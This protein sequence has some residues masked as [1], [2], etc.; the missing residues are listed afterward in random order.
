MGTICQPRFSSS[1]RTSRTNLSHSVD[2]SLAFDTNVSQRRLQMQ[3]VRIA[4]VHYRF[5]QN[6]QTHCIPRISF[7]G[8]QGLT[9]DRSMLN[10]CALLGLSSISQELSYSSDRQTTAL[11]QFSRRRIKDA[12]LFLATC[13][14]SPT[15]YVRPTRKRPKTSQRIQL[16]EPT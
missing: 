1:S 2:R 3:F 9:L 10:L 12:R 14:I 5:I 7:N 6:P 11:T 15:M 8:C 13:C 16:E 4:A